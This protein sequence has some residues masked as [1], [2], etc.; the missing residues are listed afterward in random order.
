MGAALDAVRAWTDEHRAERIPKYFL[1]IED[2]IE[3]S[4]PN[5]SNSVEAEDFELIA[6]ALQEAVD[7]DDIL[8]EP[9][10]TQAASDAAVQAVQDDLDA[11]QATYDAYVLAHP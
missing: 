2:G 6:E 10:I 5:L 4:V 9:V 7:E 8:E 11:L 3:K 1:I